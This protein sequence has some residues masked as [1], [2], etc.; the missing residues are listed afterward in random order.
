MADKQKKPNLRVIPTKVYHCKNLT[1]NAK[2]LMCEIII[3]C[4]GKGHC[5]ASNQYLAEIFNVNRMTISKWI[6]A[7]KKNGFIKCKKLRDNKRNIF[8]N[9]PIQN[10]LEV[11]RKF[12]LTY[13][14][15]NLHIKEQQGQLQK[16]DPACKNDFEMEEKEWIDRKGK[17]HKTVSIDYGEEN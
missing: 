16:T 4:N 8:I 6:K 5:W 17:K 14:S 7:L 2:L 12:Y 13:I 10:D 3:L 9:E 15:N 11:Y 1:A